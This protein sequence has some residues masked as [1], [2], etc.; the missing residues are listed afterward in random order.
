MDPVKS[1]HAYRVPRG[2]MPTFPA[3]PVFREAADPA[4]VA[5]QLYSSIASSKARKK[6]AA[7]DAAALAASD[8]R[9]GRRKSPSRSGERAGEEAEGG[10]LVVQFPPSLK[11]PS[12][13]RD[14]HAVARLSCVHLMLYS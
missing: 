8:G 6:A 13:I 12:K 1:K 10:A 11:V 7:D 5:A 14:V 2:G 3:T 9:G 4:S